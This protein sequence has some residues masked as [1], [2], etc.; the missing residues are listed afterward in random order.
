MG[1]GNKSN[2]G[3][4][5]RLWRGKRRTRW[6]AAALVARPVFPP[7]VLRWAAG[8]GLGINLPVNP[9]FGAGA[10]LEG[11]V[12]SAPEA[13]G[14]AGQSAGIVSAPGSSGGA[15]QTAGIVNSPGSSGGSGLEVLVDV[16]NTPTSMAEQARALV[17]GRAYTQPQ[18]ATF[19]LRATATLDMT[20]PLAFGVVLLAPGSANVVVTAVELE[21]TAG[22]GVT[23][24]AV[25]SV[26]IDQADASVVPAT[27][28]TNFRLAGDVYSLVAQGKSR[29]L[30]PSEVLVLVVSQGAVGT[31]LDV[32]ANVIGF[33]V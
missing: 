5:M 24:D 12:A 9:S 14:G 30:L 4:I 7:D 8:A 3:R 1:L 15:G 21:C 22:A 33:F 23:V 13:A 17:S 28:L 2:S 31:T 19:R 29:L 25:A 20:Q 18:A 16:N 26:G 32:V 6:F 27:T 10:G 11:G